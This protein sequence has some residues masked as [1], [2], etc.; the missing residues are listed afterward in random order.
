MKPI[1]TS[2]LLPQPWK[3]GGG[4]LRELLL[5]PAGE[6]WQVRVAVADIEADG[7]FSEFPGVERW[8]TLLEGAGVE[9]TLG[10]PAQTSINRLTPGSPPLCFD[11]GTPTRCRLLGGSVRAL[12]LMLRGALGR[13]EPVVDGQSWSADASSCGIYSSVAGRCNG[14]QM[15]ADSLLWFDAAPASLSFTASA[16]CPGTSA[17]WLAATAQAL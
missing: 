1:V 14:I 3:N 10:E 4:V 17:W 11:G 8:F 16:H 2:Q 13:T 9:L 7:P 15:P 6:A 5:K 12:N